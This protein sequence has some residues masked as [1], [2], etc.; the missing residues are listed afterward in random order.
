MTQALLMTSDDHAE[1]YKAFTEGREA[2]NGPAG[3]RR[4]T[5]SS[6]R[7]PSPTR[8][9]SRTRSSRPRD[10]PSISAVRPRTTRRNDRGRL[11]IVEQFAQ[12]AANVVAALEA[13]GAAPEHLVSMQIYVTDV[14]AY[15]AGSRIWPAPTA[16]TSDVTTRR[17]RLFE[18]SRSCST[19]RRKV[20]LV[21]TAVVP[22]DQR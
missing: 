22:D 8:S 15:R 16:S 7:R 19:P 4:R 17:S 2:R 9:A 14:A 3:D 12:A 1:F 5:R 11:D 10:E 13:A 20:E 18:V 6:T 21:C